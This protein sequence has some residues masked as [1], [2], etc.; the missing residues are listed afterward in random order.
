MPSPG[1]VSTPVSIVPSVTRKMPGKRA[2]HARFAA[3]TY[4][5]EFASM[6]ATPGTWAAKPAE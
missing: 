1:P 3:G 4:C 5:R 2:S 6:A